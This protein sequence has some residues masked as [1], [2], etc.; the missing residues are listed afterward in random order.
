MSRPK[1]VRLYGRADSFKL[2]FSHEGGTTWICKVP[3]DTNDG[4]Y[5]VEITAVNEIGEIAYWTGELYMCDGD[6]KVELY[7]GDFVLWFAPFSNIKVCLE[8]TDIEVGAEASSIEII[9]ILT[10]LTVKKGCIYD[11]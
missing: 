10:K 7:K 4:I 5:A 2:E 1:I 6:C 9:N 3:P 8:S 11:R